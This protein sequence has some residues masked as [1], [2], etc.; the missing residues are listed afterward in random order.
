[1]LQQRAARV[2]IVHQRGSCEGCHKLGLDGTAVCLA[3][4][5]LHVRASRS[6]STHAQASSHAVSDV[7]ATQRI[8][9]DS[10]RAGACQTLQHAV[11][12]LGLAQEYSGLQGAKVGNPHERAGTGRKEITSA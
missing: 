9:L 10:V 8:G 2:D 1:M 7:G 4:G 6:W 5:N 11:K 12:Y 3:I